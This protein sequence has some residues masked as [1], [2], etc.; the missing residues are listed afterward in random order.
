MIY[1]NLSVSRTVENTCKEESGLFH[2]LIRFKNTMLSI[3]II[4]LTLK[5]EFSH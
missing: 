2:L 5:L 4:I 3:L 1:Q